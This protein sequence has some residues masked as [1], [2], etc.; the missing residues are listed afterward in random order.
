MT[1]IELYRNLAS[2]NGNNVGMVSHEISDDIGN[3]I[4]SRK[5]IGTLQK[6]WRTIQK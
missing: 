6:H 4:N 5:W 2:L 3:L 1:K